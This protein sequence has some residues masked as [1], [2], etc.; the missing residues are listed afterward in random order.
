VRLNRAV[1]I[2]EADGPLAGLKALD[3]V[4]LPGHRLPGVRG[5]LLARV[6]RTDEAR[7]ELARAVEL[8]DNEPERA[9]LADL[10]ARL[11]G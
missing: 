2:S 6:G 3:G 7:A 9:H 8:C 4:D 11:D 5:Q 10:L 1:A